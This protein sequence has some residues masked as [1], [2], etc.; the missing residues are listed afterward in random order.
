MEIKLPGISEQ[1]Q[2]I[3]AAG[4]DEAIYQLQKNKSARV[5]RPMIEVDESKYPRTHLLREHEGW[6]PPHPDIVGAYFRHFQSFCVEYDT[7]AKLSALLGLTSDRRVREFKQGS[8][9]VPFGVWRKFLVMTGRAVQ[10]IIPV[11]FITSGNHNV[12]CDECGGLGYYTPEIEEIQCPK[13]KGN[14]FL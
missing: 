1:Q 10:D 8:R 6:E 12:D 4:I 13:C 7:D 14:G 11:K 2:F 5:V 3:F 9:T